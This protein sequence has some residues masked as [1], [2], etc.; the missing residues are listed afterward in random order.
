MSRTTLAILVAL[1]AGLALAPAAQACTLAAPATQDPVR[2]AQQRVRSAD[3]A[4][5]GVVLS[6]RVLEPPATA[7]PPAGEPPPTS[8]VG[9]EFEARVRV[10]RV[11]EGLTWRVVRVRG[12]TN[13]ALCGI[14]RLRPRQRVGLLLDRP[15]R[16]FRV[17]LASRTTLSE[18]LRGAHGRWRSPL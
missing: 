4:V 16:P 15:A 12:N 6:V 8:I 1:A 14:G 3:V 11:F 18:L 7:E 13:G 2:A 17:S 10:T 5:Y 9:E